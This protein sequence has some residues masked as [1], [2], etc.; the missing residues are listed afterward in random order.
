MYLVL[1]QELVGI[2]KS[3]Y[4][5]EPGLT[6]VLRDTIA[7]TMTDASSSDFTH[8]RVSQL[9]S[10]RRRLQAQSTA[11]ISVYFTVRVSSVRSVAQLYSEL[12]SAVTSGSFNTLLWDRASAAN[13]TALQGCTARGVSQP[14]DD[15]EGSLS[16][17]GIV[18][19]AVGAF[20]A[21][22][23]LSLGTAF[24]FWKKNTRLYAGKLML[25]VVY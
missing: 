5:A 6:A 10:S 12:S 25:R 2:S 14:A 21:V 1:S 3:A 7:D 16:L 15:S 24:Y 13:A 20:V 11:S 18:G 9:S 4:D 19:I 23:L 17:G 22:I 8:W